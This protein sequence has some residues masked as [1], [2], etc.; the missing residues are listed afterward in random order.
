MIND[1][2]NIIKGIEGALVCWYEFKHNGKVLYIGHKEDPVVENL[3]CQG[4]DITI[5]SEEESFADK[6]VG[7]FD[8]IVAVEKLEKCRRP[9][10]ILY[11]WKKHLNPDGR[12]LLGMN[13]RLGIRYFCGDRDPYTNRNFDSIE[14][15]R[16]VYIKD[17]DTFVGRMYSRAE[18]SNMLTEA[19]WK[20]FKFFSVLSDLKNASWIYAEDFLPNEDLGNR[21]FPTYH[22]PDSVFLEE[23]TLYQTLIENG[24]FHQ[25]ANA[26][27]IECSMHGIFSDVSHVT[28][29]LER[30]REDA[31]LTVIHKSNIVEKRAAYPEGRDRLWQI[32]EN[33]KSL[34]EHGL[35]VVDG[36]LKNDSYVM[37]FVN[38]EVGQLHLKKLLQVDKDEFLR[39]FDY[40]RELVLKSS[41]IVKQD[42]GD[43]EG[44][45]LRKGYLDLV[46]LNCFYINGDFTFYDQEFCMENWPLNAIV[47]RMISTF[48]AGSPESQKILPMEE[49]L[50]R[51]GLKAKL[52][53]WQDMD[54][55]FLIKLR[56]EEELR[57]YHETC[58][59]N[60]E[61]VNV[62]RRHINYS[63]SDYQRLF[64]DIFRNLEDKNLIIFGSG[65][66]A[67]TF[68]TLYAKDYPVYAV[69]DNSKSKWG[70]ALREHEIQSPELLKSLP[71]GT[72]KVIICIK[73]YLSVL[74]QLDS[75]GI[76]DY[77]IFD[78]GKYYPRKKQ[79]IIQEE[80]SAVVQKKYHIGYVA[81][82]FDMFHVGH[83]NLL[84]KA[85]EQC[86]YLIVGVVPDEYVYRQKQKYPMIPCSDRV[87]V[88]RAC[89]Y[90]DQAEELPADY[91]GI[92]DA[93]KM[94]RFDCQFSGD[95]HV[96]HT[97]WLADRK[98]L[99]KYGADIVF[100]PYTEKV[101][102]SMLREQLNLCGE[103]VDLPV[104][105]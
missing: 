20:H 76:Q 55:R 34:K 83:V 38:A 46:P 3:K 44:V 27:L 52:S 43:G 51:Y 89:K 102:S 7:K 75:W 96:C 28:S 94:F 13:N 71:A 9:V 65:K 60:I 73:K 39:E 32:H 79:T 78:P 37:P 41:E 42:A 84:R 74:Q 50:E 64:A 88:L 31:L 66:Y 63:E 99:E 33:M 29:S 15:Y 56:K 100:F 49:L 68:M 40:F 92:R 85:K 21:I 1:A 48:Y 105:D 35:S 70:E 11:Q 23:E 25:M 80:G 5:M 53:K 24:M 81:G 8:Y 77:V 26:Y 18:I 57:V 45:I 14:N 17:T 59:R 2:E 62:N 47:W 91:T 10:D 12:M 16:R 67:Q 72:Y 98:F 19:G 101:S 30:G 4:L 87:E 6:I 95:D 61:V 69:V 22:Y 97:D 86:D 103:N 36:E 93:Y 58:R 90:V 104:E 82:V 54:G